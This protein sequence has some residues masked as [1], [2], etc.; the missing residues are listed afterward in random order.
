[1]LRGVLRFIGIRPRPPSRLQSAAT[2]I[3]NTA[4]GEESSEFGNHA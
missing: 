1:M 2:L 4:L 3:L